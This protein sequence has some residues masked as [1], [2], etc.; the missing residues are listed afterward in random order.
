MVV[1]KRLIELGTVA[2]GRA[3]FEYLTRG[4][5][6][7]IGTDDDGGGSTPLGWS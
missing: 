5:D 6:E 3:E 1:M 7:S 2:A 4:E